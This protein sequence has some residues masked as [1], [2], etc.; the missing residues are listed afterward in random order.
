MAAQH[1]ALR[2]IRRTALLSRGCFKFSQEI[3]DRPALRRGFGRDTDEGLIDAKKFRNTCQRRA[4]LGETGRHGR[5]EVSGVQLAAL[6][7]Q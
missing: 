4:Q 2:H 3:G 6:R 5:R 1:L 7:T